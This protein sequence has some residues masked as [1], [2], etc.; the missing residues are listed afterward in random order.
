[1]ARLENYI[2]ASGGTLGEATLGHQMGFIY[3]R[4]QEVKTQ[5]SAVKEFTKNALACQ[6][7]QQIMFLI[8]HF[9]KSCGLILS[10]RVELISIF[11]ALS[12]AQENTKSVKKAKE[13]AYAPLEIIMDR[14]QTLDETVKQMQSNSKVRY[15]QALFKVVYK[16]KRLGK[17]TKLVVTKQQVS[18]SIFSRHLALLEIIFPKKTIFGRTKQDS[19]SYRLMR[20]LIS[21]D[22]VEICLVPETEKTV[23]FVELRID[24]EIFIFQCED[25]KHRKDL[26]QQF[27]LIK[28]EACPHSTHNTFSV[29]TII[30]TCLDPK[31]LHWRLSTEERS[32]S[33]ENEMF[34]REQQ[35][36]Y[37]H[38]HTKTGEPRERPDIKLCDPQKFKSDEMANTSVVTTN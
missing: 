26:Y 31:K 35:G 20:P 30:I 12:L 11:N 22:L 37:A 27:R 17:S 36:N 14:R 21:L 38:Y 1:M 7:W 24:G 6:K 2:R 23:N 13:K 16:P 3:R 34:I 18:L 15:N 19:W 25:Q 32:T 4:F 33:S 28:Q 9:E 29:H 10:A 8:D 5:V